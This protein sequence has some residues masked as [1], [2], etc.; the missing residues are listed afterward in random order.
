MSIVYS[1]YRRDGKSLGCVGMIGPTSMDYSKT[2]PLV[3]MMAG[4]ITA[5]LSK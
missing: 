4:Y 5:S 1:D 2:L 3:D